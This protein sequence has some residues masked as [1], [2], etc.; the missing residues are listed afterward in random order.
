MMAMHS[1][2]RKTWEK[3]VTC[4]GLYAVML[5]LLVASSHLMADGTNAAPVQAAPAA[6][7]TSSDSG[8]GKYLS[9]NMDYLTPFFDKHGDELITQGLPLALA[10]IG[11]IILL[12]LLIGWIFD[13]GIGYGFSVWFAPA[14]AKLKRALIYGAARL[15]L[16]IGLGIIGGLVLIGMSMINPYL[17]IFGVLLMIVVTL[18]AETILI[19]M[20]YRTNTAVSAV[21]Y[22]CLI[23]VHL[24]IGG[25]VSGPLIKSRVAMMMSQFIGKNVTTQLNASIAESKHDLSV[26]QQADDK[27]KADLADVQNRLDQANTEQTRL[28]NEIEARKNSEDYI[29]AGI[30]R[31]HA[32]GDLTAARDQFTAFLSKFPSGTREI[33]VKAQLTQIQSEIAVKD[34]QQKKADADAAQ[35]KAEA[36]ADLLARAGKGEVTLSEMRQALLG[37]T[38]GEVT[39]LFGPPSETASDRWGYS[40]KMI[41]N[42]VTKQKYGLAIYFNE[43]SVQSVDYYYGK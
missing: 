40:Q 29:F 13:V 30:V 10:V 37:K 17:V 43:G 28:L 35:A 27:I 16:D 15:L 34:A 5:T 41:V 4:V 42:P 23:M 36:R 25:L 22:L 12:N 3:I 9:D 19:N 33:A 38:R 8:F 18:I 7:A 11:N 6:A 20:V 14:Y 31:L 1:K 32:Q 21:F 26:A 2:C 39:D 24:I